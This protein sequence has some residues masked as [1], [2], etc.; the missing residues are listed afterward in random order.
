MHGVMGVDGLIFGILVV[1]SFVNGPL[2]G[3]ILSY[4]YDFMSYCFI[5]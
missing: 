1:T 5:T 2:G 4:E 3:I